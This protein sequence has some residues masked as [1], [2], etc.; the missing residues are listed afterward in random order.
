MEHHLEIEVVGKE[1]DL[2]IQL[3]AQGLRSMDMQTSRA[4]QQPEGG[5]HA[6]QTKTMVAMK[7]GDEDMTQLGK[8]HMTLAQLHLGAL[9]TI[10][11]QHLVTHLHHL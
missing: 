10:E 6:Y 11:H 3:S 7:M 5:D 8:A 2:T 4:P 1:A 9:G